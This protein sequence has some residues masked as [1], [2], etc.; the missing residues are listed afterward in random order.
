MLKFDEKKQ[1]GS[2]RGALAL[3]PEIERIVDEA[4]DRGFRNICWLGIGGTWA[5]AL[6]AVTHMKERTE[7]DVFS[8][9]AAEYCAT[10]DKR[11]GEGTFLIFSSVTGST[12]EVVEA[13]KKA[14]ADGAHVLGF[15]DNAD[16]PLAQMVDN[17]ITYPANEQLKF[18]MVAD[19]FLYRE[20]VMPEYGD[21]YFQFDMALPEALAEVEKSAD[22]FGEAYAK[23]HLNDKLHYFVGAGTLYGATYSYG[24]CYW[25]EMHWMRTK[26]V[27]SAEFFHG[28]LE[29]IDE[30]TPVTLFIGED[31]QRG[32][33]ERVQRFLERFS[34]N[35][36][37]IDT[38][39]YALPGIDDRYRYA[40]SHLVMHAVTNRI[41]AHLEA[42][43]GHDMN[44]RRYYRKIDY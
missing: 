14:R 31:S 37:V 35:Y 18:F 41:D 16:A 19:R 43:S 6:Q 34:K 8:A 13:V 29:I 40:V 15:I 30:D 11:V 2:V 27:H 25:E 5:S 7:L 24:M 38:K 39:T 44:I 33:G 23:A 9:N 20:G 17:R 21:M 10:G 22:G 32:L 12:A 3:R 26:S 1:I 28:M 36:T 42:L 4:W